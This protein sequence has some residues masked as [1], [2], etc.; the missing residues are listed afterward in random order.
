MVYIMFDWST[1]CVGMWT[2][3]TLT[4]WKTFDEDLVAQDMSWETLSS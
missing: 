4:K 1:H 2:M 3:S